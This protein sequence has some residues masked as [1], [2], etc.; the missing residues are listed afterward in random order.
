M[1]I[2]LMNRI[3]LLILPSNLTFIFTQY[4]S[5]KSSREVVKYNYYS[6]SYN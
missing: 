3:L 5:P 1:T 2:V 6:L 4:Y